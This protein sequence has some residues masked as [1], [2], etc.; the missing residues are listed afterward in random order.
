MVDIKHVFNNFF[1]ANLDEF[2]DN[3]GCDAEHFHCSVFCAF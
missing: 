3:N 1:D 2:T